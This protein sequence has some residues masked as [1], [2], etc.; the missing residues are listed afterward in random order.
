[1]YCTTVTNNYTV[2][3]VT[4]VFNASTVHPQLSCTVQYFWSG[5]YF[6]WCTL[7]TGSK[8]SASL[9]YVTVRGKGKMEEPLGS[10]TPYALSLPLPP[11]PRLAGHQRVYLQRSTKIGDILRQAYTIPK[12]CFLSCQNN[13]L[14]PFSHWGDSRQKYTALFRAENWT[15]KLQSIA[16]RAVVPKRRVGRDHEVCREIKKKI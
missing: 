6:C 1:M 15:Q 7:Y 2:E 8:I 3:K 13:S 14:R 11:Q 10:K 5:S 4:I 16:Y 9:S 12:L